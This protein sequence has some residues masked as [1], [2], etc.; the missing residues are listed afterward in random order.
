MVGIWLVWGRNLVPSTC[1]V[2]SKGAPRPRRCRLT[3]CAIRT[4]DLTGSSCCAV[5]KL[6]MRLAFRMPRRIGPISGGVMSKVS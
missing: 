6:P 2:S 4:T 5:L 1:P 3:R